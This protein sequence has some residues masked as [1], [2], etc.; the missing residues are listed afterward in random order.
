[1]RLSTA[2]ALKASPTVQRLI[3]EAGLDG[4][5]MMGS[6]P[7]G[8]V[9]PGDVAAAAAL[10]AAADEEAAKPMTIQLQPP[11]PYKLEGWTMPTEAVTSKAELLSKNVRDS[12]RSMRRN[13]STTTE[14]AA[15][16]EHRSSTPR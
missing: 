15:S 10:K 11:V 6:G 14:A 7:K 2:T 1:M 8:T 9:T 5:E 3:R 13:A 16:T 12:L 4:W